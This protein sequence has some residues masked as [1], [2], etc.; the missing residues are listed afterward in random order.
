MTG[1]WCHHVL[2]LI[3]WRHVRRPGKNTDTYYKVIIY[4]S[5]ALF[6]CFKSGQQYCSYVEY[7]VS[8][9]RR[10]AKSI[11]F[12]KFHLLLRTFQF[13]WEYRN[14]R[15]YDIRGAFG[16]SWTFTNRFLHS[17]QSTKMNISMLTSGNGALMR[18]TLK[19]RHWHDD[20]TNDVISTLHNDTGW[21]TAEKEKIISIK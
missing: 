21:I 18:T 10:H 5:L 4:A 19:R 20:V 6:F 15:L 1:W 11:V 9:S 8:I 2:E 7:N 3:W 17:D 14:W 16:K 12:D 13:H